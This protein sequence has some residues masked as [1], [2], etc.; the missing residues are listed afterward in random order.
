MS[1]R[2]LYC[3]GKAAKTIFNK[4]IRSICRKNQRVVLNVMFFKVRIDAGT[5]SINWL[6]GLSAAAE[7]NQSKQ[8]CDSEKVRERK[9]T[10]THH[11]I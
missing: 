11:G 1:K 6:A 9:H 3:R 2:D 5:K 8:L 10:H 7:D 4:S